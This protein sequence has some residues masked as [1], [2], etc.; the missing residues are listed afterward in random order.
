MGGGLSSRGKVAS[1]SNRNRGVVFALSSGRLKMPGNPGTL[2][3]GALAATLAMVLKVHCTSVRFGAGW[4][5]GVPRASA[6][7]VGKAGAR[8]E[9]TV[10]AP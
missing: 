7:V 8:A 3:S 9:G 2:G 4:K 10:F 6:G 5:V 1:L